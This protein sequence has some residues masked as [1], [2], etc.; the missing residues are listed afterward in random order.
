MGVFVSTTTWGV[1][2]KIEYSSA[3]NEVRVPE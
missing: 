1:D 3:E 2:R